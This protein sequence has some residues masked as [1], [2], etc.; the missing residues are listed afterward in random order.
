MAKPKLFNRAAKIDGI[1]QQPQ[2]E[3][4]TTPFIEEAVVES[5]KNK[6]EHFIDDNKRNILLG[7]GIITLLF[8][9]Y[10]AYKSFY[11]P[12]QEAAAQEAMF[13]AQKKFENGNYEA[14]LNGDGTN[15]GFDEIINSQSGS[16][17]AV[18]LAYYYAGI[19]ALNK[20]EFQKAIDY[21]KHF[22]GNDEVVGAMAL[23]AMGDA[24]SEL[25]DM[26]NGINYYKQAA[27][28]SR[29]E[30][31]GPMFLMKAGMASETNNDFATAKGLY[32]Q[33]KQL[34]P[35]STYARDADKYIARAEAKSAGGGAH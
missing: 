17:K 7:L 27:N 14:A 2:I 18:N 19:C 10:F 29:N 22:E 16:T 26:A 31:T 23:G 35:E 11:L 32:E 8:V 5:Y 15:P 6:L 24:Y 21:L 9:G 1:D 25:G 34:Y 4:T 3:E 12:R 13:M 20:G 30:F 33:I 28:H